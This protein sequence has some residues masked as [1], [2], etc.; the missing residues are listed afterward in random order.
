MQQPKMIVL[1]LLA[2]GMKYGL[3]MEKFVE[4]TNMRL[5]ARI[6]NSTIYK[7]LLD[8]QKDGRVE[9]RTEAAERGPGKTVYRLT[10]KGRKDF[11]ALVGEAM[12]SEDP[13]YS[14]RI[15]GLVFSLSLPPGKVDALI[16]KSIAGLSEGL[17]EIARQ[18]TV[19]KEDK[20]AQVVLDFYET[21]YRA[22]QAA[23]EKVKKILPAPPGHPGR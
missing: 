20:L 1:G 4:A 14:D 22:E 17:K 2:Q 9:A 12:F 6:G 21:V 13:V 3:E 5:W 11:A 16:G 8:L 7:A 19:R 23:M 10:K 15:A 18:K